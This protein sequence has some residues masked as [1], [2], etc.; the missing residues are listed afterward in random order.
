MYGLLV[1]V[2]PDS[3]NPDWLTAGSH[4]S[5]FRGSR[6]QNASTL[7]HWD[8]RYPNDPNT[9]QK[10]HVGP[11]PD[12]ADCFHASSILPVHTPETKL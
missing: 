2:I 3:L 5:E 7:C 4:L 9:N 1:P 11:F 8:P 12:G 6:F 10:I